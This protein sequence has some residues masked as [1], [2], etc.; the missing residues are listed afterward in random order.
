MVA[1]SSILALDL[2]EAR[3]GL[4][5]ASR[6]ARLA[7]PAGT[8]RH[9]SQLV[10]H[11]QDLCKQEAV[12][13]LVIGLPRGLDGQNTHQTDIARNFGQ[14]IAKSLNIPV[15]WQ[16]EAVTSAQAETEL[17]TKGKSYTKEDIDSLAATYI[18]EDYLRDQ[19]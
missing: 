8:L 3:V 13:Q 12:T 14:N 9:D 1:H 11:L 6:E 16:D 18:L 7:H 10:Q 19:V 5:L 2:G 17:K 15:S 4:A